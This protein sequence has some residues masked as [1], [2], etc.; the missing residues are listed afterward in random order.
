MIRNTLNTACYGTILLILLF[1]SSNIT[2]LTIASAV[3]GEEID[4]IIRS[5]EAISSTFR[6]ILKAEEFGANTSNLIQEL[7]KAL[8]VLPEIKADFI[9]GNYEEAAR[10]TDILINVTDNIKAEASVLG[11]SARA[12]NYD[13]FAYSLITLAAG[14]PSFILVMLAIWRW[15]NNRYEHKNRGQETINGLTL[16]DYK[17]LFFIIGLLG[18]LLLA[19]PAISFALPQRA[20]ERFSEIYILG[21]NRMAENYPFNIE[22]NETYNIVLGIG[23]HMGTSA[24]YAIRVKIRGEGEKLPNILEKNPSPLATVYEYRVFVANNKIFEKP[25][26]FLLN[27]QLN[28]ENCIIK[29]L[30]I[31]GTTY[32]AD[33]IVRWNP[34]KNGFLINILFELWIYD[35]ESEVFRFHNRFVGIWLNMTDNM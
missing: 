16:K 35:A 22:S 18:S 10:L 4:L 8:K 6:E 13:M 33:K 7:N 27:F 2:F 15:F 17:K 1:L 19:S 24:Y 32:D 9:G 34:E 30:R 3:S 21:S 25:L 5:E 11:N 26:N 31:D 14:V 29:S 28:G 12:H 20:K 23:N